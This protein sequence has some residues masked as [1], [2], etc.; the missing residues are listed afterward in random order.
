MHVLVTAGVQRVQQSSSQD[1]LL[2][3]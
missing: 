2:R 1:K 3:A